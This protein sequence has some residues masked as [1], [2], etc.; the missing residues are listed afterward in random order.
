MILL[1]TLDPPVVLYFILGKIKTPIM[2]TKLH[3]IRVFT[4]SLVSSPTPTYF[5]SPAMQML[6]YLKRIQTSRPSPLLFPRL[7]HGLLSH[8]LQ[9]SDEYYQRGLPWAPCTKQPLP[10]H[11]PR[12]WSP[13]L[14]HFPFVALITIWQI[15]LHS[16]LSYQHLSFLRGDTL[17]FH[18]CLLCPLC[19]TVPGTQ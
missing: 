2:A 8:S 1:Q 3:M 12:S 5:P 6:R 11:Q 19:Q 4:G 17:S 10:P 13:S 14:L 7:L 18:C 15:C 9:L 16:C